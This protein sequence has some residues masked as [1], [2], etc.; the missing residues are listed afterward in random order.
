MFH[1]VFLS[2][3]DREASGMLVDNFNVTLD[4]NVPYLWPDSWAK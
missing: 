4:N 3:C 2:D 1:T